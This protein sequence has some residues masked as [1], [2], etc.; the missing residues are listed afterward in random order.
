MER[1]LS[2]EQLLS[3]IETQN[4]LAAALDVDA[5]IAVVVARAHALL[6]AAAAVVEL[7]DGADTVHH[8]TSGAAERHAGLVLPADASLSALCVQRDDLLYCADARKD[9]RVDADACRRLG[10]RSIACAPLSHG[11]RAAGVLKVYDPRPHRFDGADLTVLTLLSGLLSAHIAHAGERPQQQASGRDPLTGLLDRSRFDERLAAES[12][13]VRRHGGDVAVCLLDLDRFQRLNEAHGPATGDAV[14]RA[15][16]RRLSSVRGEDA[17]F[18]IGGDDFALILVGACQ[19]EAAQV[20]ERIAA[21]VRED[22]AA[23]AV[24]LSWGLAM[25]SDDG[26]PLATLQRADARLYEAKRAEH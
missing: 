11:G 7:L 16:A 21:S 1:E 12:A 10:A 25:L 3:L 15:V 23:H 8:T 24:A 6:G 4:E 18:R 22:P 5:A 14:L 26:D 17:A 19:E 20:L 9:E 2:G 13:R